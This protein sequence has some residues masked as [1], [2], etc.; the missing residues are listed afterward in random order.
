MR[1]IGGHFIFERFNNDQYHNTDLLLSSGRNCLRYLIRERNI[2]TLHLPYFLCETLFNVCVK[3]GIDV[4]FYHIDEKLHP[5]INETNFSDEDFVYIVNYYGLLSNDVLHQLKGKYANVI[6]DNTHDFFDKTNVGTDT[7]Y[8]YRKNFGVPEGACITGNLKLNSS[9]PTSDSVGKV[10]ELIFREE[11]NMFQHFTTFQEA[12]RFFSGEELCLMA[13][14]TKNYLS[15]IDYNHAK[16][17]REDNFESLHGVLGRYNDFN[18]SDS[19]NYMYP[20]YT[21]RGNLLRQYLKENNVYSL[22]LWPNVLSNGA[23]ELEKDL[24]Q[25]VVLLPMDQ[26]YGFEEMKYI[27]DLVTYYFETSS[28]QYSVANIE[29]H[30][31]NSQEMVLRKKRRGK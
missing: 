24:T 21:D 20:L 13:D 6:I 25:N 17:I 16:T 2:Q 7:I 10:E 1:E 28:N 18:L 27:T 3:E 22:M 23:N 31:S 30:P 15:G 9:Y 4:K 12:D 26:R 11:K 29:N 19:L 8:N 14:F 5:V